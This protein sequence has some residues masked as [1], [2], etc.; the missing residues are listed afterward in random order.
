MEYKRMKVVEIK[1]R[2]GV[3]IKFDDV[4][5]EK[6]G[7]WGWCLMKNGYVVAHLPGSGQKSNMV[8]CGRAVI[9][10]VTGEWPRKGME[11]DHINHDKLDN[12]A[13]NL[14]EVSP[15]I[16][17]RNRIPVKG[18]YKWVPFE[19][20]RGTYVGSVHLRVNGKPIK[21][22]SSRTKNRKQAAQA[23]DCISELLGGFLFPNFP[24]VSFEEKW[25]RI[26]EGQRSQIL[27]SIES[28][29]FMNERAKILTEGKRG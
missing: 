27:H 23:A 1:S 15:S 16:N 8:L 19:E 24:K 12:Q 17:Q 9:W 21:L 22:Y 2:P 13:I 28:H 20:R 14:R 5:A 18:K 25:K 7:H 26:G 3:F 29:G 10:A 6:I 11:V 4:V